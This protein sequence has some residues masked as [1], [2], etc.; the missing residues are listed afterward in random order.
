MWHIILPFLSPNTAI[1]M[2][3]WQCRRHTLHCVGMKQRINKE[4]KRKKRNASKQADMSNVVFF[5]LSVSFSFF[6]FVLLGLSSSYKQ[7]LCQTDVHSCKTCGVN[8][9]TRSK[10]GWNWKTLLSL[11]VQPHLY[12]EICAHEHISSRTRLHSWRHT[13]TNNHMPVSNQVCS[14]NYPR[15]WSVVTHE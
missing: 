7:T 2:F 1:N 10:H 11:L 15:I 5:P 12:R 4:K 3:C 13:G 8:R 6:L 9:K 14:T